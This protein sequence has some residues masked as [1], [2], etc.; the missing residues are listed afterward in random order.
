MVRKLLILY[1]IRI[2]K[3]NYMTIKYHNKITYY[4]INNKILVRG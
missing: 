3:Y 1:F 2:K 4:Y